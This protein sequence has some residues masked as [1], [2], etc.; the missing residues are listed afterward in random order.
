MNLEPYLIL[1]YMKLNPKQVIHTN[2]RFNTTKL[3]EENLG[4]NPQ[5]IGLYVLDTTP[6]YDSKMK[7]VFNLISSTQKTPVL[8]NT[9]L[10]KLKR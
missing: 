2:V 5:G 9:S 6:K 7:T 10:I 4:G 1:L 3:L 8:Q